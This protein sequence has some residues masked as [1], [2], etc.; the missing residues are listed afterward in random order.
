VPRR[1]VLRR[2]HRSCQLHDRHVLRA[3]LGHAGCGRRVS[4]GLSMP[5]GRRSR[6]VR[7]RLCVHWRDG[8][9]C[10]CSRVVRGRGLVDVHPVSSRVGDC[11]LR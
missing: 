1:L 3:G 7:R 6:A 5:G 10:V 2:G 11:K 9:S 4:G 8:A